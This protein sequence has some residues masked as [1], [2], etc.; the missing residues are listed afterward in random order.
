M[1]R[2]GKARPDRWRRPVRCGVRLRA[3]LPG[4]AGLALATPVLG[5]GD[6]ASSGA[7]G[8]MPSFLLP[9]LMA[10]GMSLTV[11]AIACR[12]FRKK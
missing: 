10:A 9:S 7:G 4:W 11:L 3:L 1:R 2:G 8:T 5:A 6:P 12:R